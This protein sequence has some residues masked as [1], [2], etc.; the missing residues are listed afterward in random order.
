MTTNQ[1]A[2]VTDEAIPPGHPDSDP[3]LRAACWAVMRE[4]GYSDETILATES[5]T[6]K[7]A[8]CEWEMN[9]YSWLCDDENGDSAH[10]VMDELDELDSTI[11]AALESVQPLIAAQAKAETLS[12]RLRE[13]CRE[14]RDELPYGTPNVPADFI[15]WGKFF[16]PEAFGPKCYDHAQKHLGHAAMSR[17]DQ[18]AVFDLR[19]AGIEAGK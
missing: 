14:C 15:L 13:H 19:A 3:I 1:D 2:T 11:H 10:P 5:L 6:H 9:T 17:I 18:Y 16:E 8:G 12:D 4:R 7:A